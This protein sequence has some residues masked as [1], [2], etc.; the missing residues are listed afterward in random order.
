MNCK[1]KHTNEIR[2]MIHEK[3]WVQQTNR[4]YKKKSTINYRDDWRI[5]KTPSKADL[6]TQKKDEVT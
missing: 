2:K 1:N 3:K 4:N 6:I 5:Q